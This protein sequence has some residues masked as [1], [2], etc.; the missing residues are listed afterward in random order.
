MIKEFLVSFGDNFREKTRN[1]FLG[2]YIFIW[3]IRN[4]ELI[5]SLFNFDNSYKLK[6]KIEFINGYYNTHSFTEG[7]LWNIALTFLVLIITYIVLNM[8]RVIINISEEQI[9][10]W[11]YKN[12]DS[13]SIV[14]KS[15]H[16]QVRNDRDKL[17]LRLDQERESKSRLEVRIK[18][19]EDEI[20]EASKQKNEEAQKNKLD[21]NGND[22]D[23]IE[24]LHDALKSGD[25]LDF[26]RKLAVR[27]NKAEYIDKGDPR[28]DHLISYG[29]IS[30]KDQALSGG[31]D[32]YNLTEDGKKLFKRARF[33]INHTE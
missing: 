5:Y 33:G 14:L 32:R 28:V 19:L 3:F 24:I 8:A 6:D 10:P 22:L 11:V 26:F 13:K 20:F 4:W 12:T 23:E 18:S 29:L 21:K 27:I 25:L 15:I 16:E 2:T 17:Q 1:P 31:A 9:K 30:H 7:I